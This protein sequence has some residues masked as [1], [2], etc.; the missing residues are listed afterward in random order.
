M[1]LTS[2]LYFNFR[3]TAMLTVILI[4]L[5]CN[6]KKRYESEKK[7]TSVTLKIDSILN[8]MTLIEK[9]GQLNMLR[10]KP[11]TPT[12]FK[13]AKYNLEE[14]IKKGR[15]G[16]FL[17]VHPMED[18]IKYQKIAVEES[19]NGI[20]LLFGIDII[21]GFRTNFPVPLGEA[22][23]W[24]L[25]LIE[26]SAKIASTEGTAVG[27]MWN[28]AP[29]V[30]ISFDARWERVMEGAGE[31]PYLGSRIAEA[32]I[33]GF[34]GDLSSTETMLACA[35]H[36][37]GY[38]QVMAGR[39]YN[40]TTISKRFLHDYILPPFQAS[41]DV[42][43]A[44]LMSAFTDFDGVPGNMN[45]YLLKDI[46]RERWDFEGIVISDF[47]SLE[48]IVNW[49]TVDS[50][51][52][53]AFKA[54]EAGTEVDMMGLVYIENLEKLIQD[55]KIKESSLN[56]AVKRVLKMKMDM[57]LFDGPYRYFKIKDPE[58]IWLQP[59]FLEHSRNIARKSMVLLKND[60]QLLPISTNKT[61]TIAVIGPVDE[62]KRNFM[63]TWSAWGKEENV[64]GVV[65]GLKNALKE[66]TIEILY[67]PGLNKDLSA[68]PELL[69]R[70]IKAAKKADVVVCTLTEG[71][72]N[73]G[74]NTSLS[75]LNMPEP[76]VD[77]IRKIHE[78]NQSTICVL[79]NGRPMIFPW[80]SENIP[81]I[82]EAWMPGTKGGDALADIL[83]G[84]YN[85]SGK[86][87]ITFP[88]N[89]GQIPISYLQKKTG[90]PY[91]TGKN[92]TR[93]LDAPN[94]PAYAFGYGLSYTTFE[95]SDI[96]L[97]TE[98]ISEN[99]TLTASINIKNTGQLAGVE[100]VQL[101]IGDAVATVTRPIKELKGFQQVS[102]EPGETKSIDFKITKEHLK[103]WNT[104]M[105]YEAD[106]GTFIIHIGT[107]S[108]DFKKTIFKLQ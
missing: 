24:N 47:N 85:P 46:L 81:A 68:N 106:P 33:K 20:P 67:E 79:F 26:K 64:V 72:R 100:T 28:M 94:E 36:F 87:P 103:Y 21:H 16:S 52:K 40:Q 30:D 41:I 31:D 101:Y 63:A 3:V 86:L 11:T 98:N 91:K 43:V 14:E 50:E 96:R 13:D 6:G 9:V 80:I 29:M 15:V 83:L 7:L 18:K 57:G 93:Y 73:S 37:A 53:A 2:R 27:F 23:S 42:D 77:L 69:N 38:G 35:K 25:E 65:D 71:W 62:D 17:N 8:K 74:E 108:D 105:K 89:T 5:S 107:N 95:Y 70:A 97:S 32:R 99:D 12:N 66:E 1:N 39:D 102:L 84:K 61:K 88:R 60:S 34:Q 44:S 76:Q 104:E 82:L 54:F 22:A 51:E 4:L 49:G 75:D 92:W 58:K 55:G 10:G 56:T 59:Q 45:S 90:R 19:P 78:V 48:E